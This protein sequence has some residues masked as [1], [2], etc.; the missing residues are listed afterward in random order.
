[1]AQGCPG[2]ILVSPRRRRYIQFVKSAARALLL[3]GLLAGACC[4]GSRPLP[5][6]IDP[7][8]RPIPTKRI[9]IYGDSRPAVT[10]ERFFTGRTDPVK[11]RSLIIARIVAEKPDLV[12]HSGDLVA[13]GSSEGHWKLWDETHK[14]IFDAKIPFY[15]ALGNHEYAG[16]TKEALGYFHKRFPELGGCRWYAVRSGP[17]LFAILDTNFDELSKERVEQ[18]DAWY[19]KTLKEAESDPEVKAVI[20]VSHHPPYTNSTTHGPSEE[21][22]RRYAKPAAAFSKFKLYVAG[23]V[24][25]Y[26]RILVGGVPFVVSGGGGAPP[27]AVRTWGFRT[28]PEY[29]GPEIRPFHYLLLAVAEDRATVD[30]MMLQPDDSWKSGDRFELRW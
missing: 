12:I 22:K 8:R 7:I 28:K 6:Q 16:D 25:N 1:M 14:A 15:P 21:T 2:V 30:T 26:E 9:V 5:A 27:T 24:H 23:H 10:G 18:Q 13:R 29:E 3:L 17:I 20:V 19:L 11:E 4:G